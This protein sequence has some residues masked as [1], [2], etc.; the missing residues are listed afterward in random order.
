MGFVAIIANE[1]LTI[2][3]SA[4]QHEVEILGLYTIEQLLLSKLEMVF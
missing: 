3:L 4:S 1:W 2:F